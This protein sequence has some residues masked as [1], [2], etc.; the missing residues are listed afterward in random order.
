MFGFLFGLL[1]L[2][3]KIIFA[4]ITYMENIL[5]PS[6]SFYPLSSVISTSVSEKRPTTQKYPC[7][8]VI[9]EKSLWGKVAS[10]NIWFQ[11]RPLQACIWDLPLS[12]S[13][14]TFVIY[15]NLSPEPQLIQVLS[16]PKFMGE[17]FEV[18]YWCSDFRD[19]SCVY[20]G[21]FLFFRNMS[22]LDFM[23]RWNRCLS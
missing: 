16:I 13:H 6:F 9:P 20:V 11:V 12:L 7:P 21:F 19:S 18:S 22:S 10:W 23:R 1:I 5:M 3:L 14:H 4:L 17:G 2:K 15:S 8:R